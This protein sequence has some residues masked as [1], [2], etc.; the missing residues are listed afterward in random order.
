MERAPFVVLF[1]PRQKKLLG[2]LRTD[3]ELTIA[4]AFELRGHVGLE[5]QAVPENQV[6][7]SHLFD[8]LGRGLVGVG[9]A[10][11]THHRRD[12]GVWGD[13][14]DGIGEVA[15]RRV[16]GECERHGSEGNDGSAC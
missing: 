5:V 3:S 4:E 9:I 2:D 1:W 13:V 14:R 10:S 7:A 16:H 6:G 15:R 12:L 11:G 8:V